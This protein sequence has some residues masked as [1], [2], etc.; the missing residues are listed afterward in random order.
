[1]MTFMKG[2]IDREPSSVTAASARRTRKMAARRW[3]RRLHHHFGEGYLERAMRFELTTPT[4]AKPDSR[5]FLKSEAF[6]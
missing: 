6:R 3:K 4:L 1:M 2:E 5:V